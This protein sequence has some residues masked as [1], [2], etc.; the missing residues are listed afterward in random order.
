L[1]IENVSKIQAMTRASVPTSGAGISRSGPIS[2][3]ISLV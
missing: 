2:L 1:F 3:M